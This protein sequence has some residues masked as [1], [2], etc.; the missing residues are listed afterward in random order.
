[1][2]NKHDF[3]IAREKLEQIILAKIGNSCYQNYRLTNFEMS[4][5]HGRVVLTDPICGAGES[6]TVEVTWD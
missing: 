5:R 2:L 6:L 3:M 1:M 4:D